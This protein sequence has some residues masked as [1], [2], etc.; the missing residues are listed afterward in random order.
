MLDQSDVVLR[1]SHEHRDLVEA[2][3]GASLAQDASGDFDG[4]SALARCGEEL[5]RAVQLSLGRQCVRAE[6]ISTQAGQVARSISTAILDDASHR[7][8]SCDAF[9][10]AGGHRGKGRLSPRNQRCDE[11]Q[12][13][14]AIDREID[15]HHERRRM[16]APD[17]VGGSVEQ[18]GTIDARGTVE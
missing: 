12:F 8:E 9:S 7:F 2:H 13:S 6:E 18:R 1:R 11:G 3:A 16:C 17:H 10:I 5:E 4:F 14:A 15:Q